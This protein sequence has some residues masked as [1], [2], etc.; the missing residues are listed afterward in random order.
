M[1]HPLPAKRLLFQQITTCIASFASI[2]L[3]S[4]VS[5][6]EKFRFERQLMG[7]RFMIVCYTHDKDRARQAAETAFTLAEDINK[8]A[9]DHVNDSEL[10]KLSGAATGSTVV[11]SPLLFDLV[12]HSRL[13]AD[14]TGGAFDPTLGP[15][16]KLWRETRSSGLLRDAEALASAREAIGW[17]HFTLDASTRCIT[18]HKANMRFDLGAVAKGYAADLMLESLAKAG[19]K[20]A[21][22]AAGGDIRLGDPP[23]GREGW[24]VAVTTFDSTKADEVLVLSNAAVSTSGDLHQSVEID[25]VTYSHILDPNTGLGLTRRVAATV[26]AS[27]AKFSDPI[28]TAACVL[29]P[30]ASDA[31]KKLPGVRE[32]KIRILTYSP[33]STR[34]GN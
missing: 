15:L 25:G 27:E 7:T 2:V 16:T 13:I 19:I 21:M 5:A 32:V 26:I 9:S 1:N 4:V 10:A 29:G 24:R 28:S 34:S 18:L 33:D 20:Y 3:A 30:D 17:K 11:I 31:L 12:K 6:E 23:P 14:V 22:I 8:V